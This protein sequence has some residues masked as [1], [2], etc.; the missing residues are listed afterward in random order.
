MAGYPARLGKPGVPSGPT[1]GRAMALERARAAELDFG[2]GLEL[3]LGSASINKRVGAGDGG[4]LED[5]RASRSSHALEGGGRGG[6]LSCLAGGGDRVPSSRRLHANSNSPTSISFSTLV[7]PKPPSGSPTAS[8]SS[9]TRTNPLRSPS[10]LAKMGL[11]INSP[12]GLSASPALPT[13]PTSPSRF[14]LHRNASSS[15]LAAPASPNSVKR[16]VSL[17]GVP[18]ALPTLRRAKS[19]KRL[20]SRSSI[21]VGVGV[22]LDGDGHRVLTRRTSFP[23]LR[24]AREVRSC[25]DPGHGRCEAR[26]EGSEDEADEARTPPVP[27][28]RTKRCFGVGEGEL[29]DEE[30]EL[31]SAGHGAE[32]PVFSSSGYGQKHG[33]SAARSYAMEGSGSSYSSYSSFGSAESHASSWSNGTDATSTGTGSPSISLTA[34]TPT[35]QD[36]SGTPWLAQSNRGSSLTWAAEPDELRNR[37]SPLPSIAKRSSLTRD[38]DSPVALGPPFGQAQQSSTSNLVPIG[39][40]PYLQPIRNCHLATPPAAELRSCVRNPYLTSLNYPA[41]QPHRYTIS[42]FHYQTIP[43]PAPSSI[44]QR[45]LRRRSAPQNYQPSLPPGAAA[46]VVTSSSYPSFAQEQRQTGPPTSV[47][48]MAG[49]ASPG[50]GAGMTRLLRRAS[51]SLN[52]A[53]GWPLSA[54]HAATGPGTPNGAGL[55]TGPACEAQPA[56]PARERRVRSKSSGYGIGLEVVKEDVDGWAPAMMSPWA[57]GTLKVSRALLAPSVAANTSADKQFHCGVL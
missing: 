1:P 5:S 35:K 14:S 36:T 31:S 28:R 49:G 15:S 3:G 2:G 4:V 53:G 17:L 30:E 12:S 42:A 55:G 18:L 52:G 37:E 43:Q 46:P 38:S 48:D 22:G 7:Y 23:S 21:G 47:P 10:K 9:P 27:V 26:C 11:C 54:A 34:S 25:S 44:S 50:K 6:A 24:K 33:R 40:D 41:P 56:S 19:E 32:Q 51:A 16:R 13:S 8:P 20:R 45:L 39:Y 29:S 57:S